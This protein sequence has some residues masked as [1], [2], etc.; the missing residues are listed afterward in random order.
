MKKKLLSLGLCILMLISLFPVSAF[1]AGSASTVEKIEQFLPD[2]PSPELKSQI[3]KE[4]EYLRSSGLLEENVGR[5]VDIRI[6]DSI[7]AYPGAAATIEYKIDYDLFKETLT[8]T[9]FSA[10][11]VSFHSES[12]DGNAKNDMTINSDNSIILDGQQIDTSAPTTSISPKVS[13]RWYQSACPYGAPRDY[14]KTAGMTYIDNLPLTNAII[15]MT[16]SAV[17]KL[18]L[19]FAGMPV[20]ASKVFTKVTFA[21]MQASAP[22]SQGLSC[23]DAKYWHKNS[24][25]AGYISAYGAYVTYHRIQWYPW[26]NQKGNPVPAYE[27]EIYRIY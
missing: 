27:F 17:Y 7:P 24:G 20:V 14:T 18:I 16:F 5:I 4:Y 10:S 22:Q 2:S 15:K 23:I 12:E 26:I 25:S 9:N 21:A 8:F 6:I 13:D 3:E 1:A 11:S 19:G